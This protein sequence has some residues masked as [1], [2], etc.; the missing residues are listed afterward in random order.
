MT[1]LGIYFRYIQVY[2]DYEFVNDP[3][4]HNGEFC[5]HDGLWGK[6]FASKSPITQRSTAW[7]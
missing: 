1:I 6:Y 7:S 2:S 4:L 5:H 3:S